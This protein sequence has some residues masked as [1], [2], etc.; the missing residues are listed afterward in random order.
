MEKFKLNK[1]V[2]ASVSKSRLELHKTITKQ[3]AK[4]KRKVY[5]LRPLGS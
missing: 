4:S 1:S 3:I 2:E 5:V